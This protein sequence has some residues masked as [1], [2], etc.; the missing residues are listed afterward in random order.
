MEEENQVLAE[1]AEAVE[2]HKNLESEDLIFNYQ[3]KE[4]AKKKLEAS[5]KDIDDLFGSLLQDVPDPSEEDVRKGVAKILQRA[6]AGRAQT[7]EKVQ[8]AET[9]QIKPIKAGKSKKVT[10][11][12]LLLAA[13]L[14]ILLFS[15]LFVMGSRHNISIE[16]GF[17]SFA[18]DTVQVVFFGEGE[19]KF[20]SVDSLLESLKSKGYDDIVFPQEF[21]TRSDEYKV[22]VPEYKNDDVRQADFKIHNQETTFSFII[23]QLKSTQQPYGY[24]DLGDSNTVTVGDVA[25]DVFDFGNDGSAIQFLYDK[26]RYYIRTNIHYSDMV[27][28]AETI[29]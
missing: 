2:H 27:K 6:A 8:A 5:M 9:V 23:C 1:T 19:E 25:V 21:V 11:K 22:S 13:L 29:R 28:I 15:T 3:N 16:N 10:L 18:K 17:M 14:S 7:A 26:Y 24:L 20:I 12:V 4:E